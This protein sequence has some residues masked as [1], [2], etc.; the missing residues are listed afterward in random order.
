M[1]RLTVLIMLGLAACSVFATGEQAG[2]GAGDMAG[3]RMVSGKA[4]SRAE[5]AAL[6]AACQDGA[7]PHG[8]TTSLDT[9][10]AGLGLKREP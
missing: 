10:L 1:P 5:Y 3:W 8:P 7:L 9:C 2:P 4:P 6:V